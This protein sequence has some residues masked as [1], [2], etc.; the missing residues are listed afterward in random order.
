MAYQEQKAQT[1]CCSSPQSHQK[2]PLEMAQ[3]YLVDAE[4]DAGLAHCALQAAKVA[5]SAAAEA[6]EKVS[7]VYQCAQRR[8]ERYQDL[9]SV[10]ARL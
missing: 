3:Q 2:S 8:I 10:L 4:R 9:I 6:L 5:H 1:E 7:R